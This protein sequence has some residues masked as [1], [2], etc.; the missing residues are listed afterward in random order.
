MSSKLKKLIMPVLVR[1][2]M[3]MYW[4]HYLIVYVNSFGWALLS[5]FYK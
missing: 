5:L 3:Y 1:C 4:F 2:F